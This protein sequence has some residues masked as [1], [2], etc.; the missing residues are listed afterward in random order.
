MALPDVTPATVQERAWSSPIW[1][2]PSAEARKG[3]TPGMTVAELTGKGGVAL[4]D[5][6]LKALLVGKAHWLRNTV[7]GEA[8]KASFDE[9][10]NVFVNHVGSRAALPGAVGNLSGSSYQVVP[11]PYTLKN[12]KV[13]TMLGNTALELTFYKMGDQYFAARGNEFGYVNYEMLPT[14]PANLVPLGKGEYEKAS[15]PAYLHTKTEE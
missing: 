13:V 8:F 9:T 15:H 7:T 1:Y 6:Q 5:D 3:A 2:T 10:G 14:G 4:N 12:G 11:T